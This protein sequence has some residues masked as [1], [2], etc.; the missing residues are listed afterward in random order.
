MGCN[1]SKAFK[2]KDAATA[3][4]AQSSTVVGS[5]HTSEKPLSSHKE[6]LSPPTPTADTDLINAAPTK[7]GYG[8]SSSPLRGVGSQTYSQPHPNTYLAPPINPTRVKGAAMVEGTA[9]SLA[10]E[11]MVVHPVA[12]VQGYLAVAVLVAEVL[13]SN[14]RGAPACNELLGWN[15]NPWDA[16]FTGPVYM[17]VKLALGGH[18]SHLNQLEG[19]T[20][21]LGTAKGRC[22]ARKKAAML[23]IDFPERHPRSK[24]YK[25][26]LPQ[27]VIENVRTCKTDASVY[28][29]GFKRPEPS[30]TVTIS[31]YFPVERRS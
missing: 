26:D 12:R 30:D 3:T 9:E 19:T 7:K 24:K 11:A 20:Y 15:N 6:N 4:T 23:D 10:T 22:Q 13:V 14:I 17:R 1:S 5:P 2:E 25:A 31:N 28:L 27:S 29:P 21:E 16:G 8:Y 18:E